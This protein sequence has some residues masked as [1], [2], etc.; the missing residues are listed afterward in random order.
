MR[1]GPD[2]MEPKTLVLRKD[3]HWYVISSADGDEEKILLTLL[4]HA[5]NRTYNVE[6]D[7]VLQLIDHLG[8]RL[9]VYEDMGL[10]S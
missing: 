7:D 9:E 6:T 10:A 3:R 5:E 2:A 4:E 8:W 1:K